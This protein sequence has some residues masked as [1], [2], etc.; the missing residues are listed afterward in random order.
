[1]SGEVAKKRWRQLRGLVEG[2]RGWGELMEVQYQRCELL[3]S[4]SQAL[5]LR[6][7]W[8]GCS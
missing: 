8:E 4:C 7:A 2:G 3:G 6:T 5:Q 1:M